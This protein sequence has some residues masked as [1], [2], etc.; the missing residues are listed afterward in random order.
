METWFR[1]LLNAISVVVMVGGIGVAGVLDRDAGTFECP[2]CGER[3][4]PDMKAYIMGTHTLTKR[5]LKCPN[6]GERSYCK[7]ELSR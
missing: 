4:T 3:F 1:I 7:H 5:Y 6:C 2:K